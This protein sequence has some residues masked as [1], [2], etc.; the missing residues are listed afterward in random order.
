MGL[1]T[2]V[3]TADGGVEPADHKTDVWAWRHPHQADGTVTYTRL[4]GEIVMKSVLIEPG[5]RTSGDTT[6]VFQSK[7]TITLVTNCCNYSIENL[8]TKSI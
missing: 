4:R 6:G 5:R 7:K 1:V 3:E 8:K 2:A